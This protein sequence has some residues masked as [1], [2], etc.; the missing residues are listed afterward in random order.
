[1]NYAAGPRMVT[2]AGTDG[3]TKAGMEVDVETE[4]GNFV[5]PYPIPR[6]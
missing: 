4:H 3:G 6:L 5:R 2:E 1:M